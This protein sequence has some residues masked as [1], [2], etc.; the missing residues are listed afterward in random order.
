MALVQFADI[1]AAGTLAVKDNATI[2]GTLTAT[3]ATTI[4]GA[5]TAT[6]ATTIGGALT[7]SGNINFPGF[8]VAG[9]HQ[10]MPITNVITMTSVQAAAG[11][12]S[13]VTIFRNVTVKDWNISMINGATCTG[14]T[15]FAVTLNKS[16]AG[17]GALVALG[18]A[19]LAGTAANLSVVDAAVTTGTDANCLAGDDIIVATVAGTALPAD[20]I[21]Y[22]AYMDYVERL[23]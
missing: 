5:L 8:N 21:Q 11:N 2:G 4:G 19:T 6:G 13:R 17:T 20:S 15:A 7:A 9:V 18:T 1:E 14:A 10:Q 22:V 12:A 16:L 23:V 3:G